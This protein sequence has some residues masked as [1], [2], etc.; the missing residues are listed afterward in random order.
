VKT[1]SVRDD[2]ATTWP[3]HFENEK[4]VFHDAPAVSGALNLFFL[5]GCRRVRRLRVLWR[6]PRVHWRDGGDLFSPGHF[7]FEAA[8]EIGHALCLHHICSIGGEPETFFGHDCNSDSDK[9]FLMYPTIA[10]T[11]AALDMGQ[12]EPACM[13]ATH[14]EDGKTSALPESAFFGGSSRQCTLED[15]LN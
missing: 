14:F 1:I 7:N 11:G 4:K 15:E 9:G 8:H 6:R 13:G 12:I 5:R 3:K 2:W 10:A